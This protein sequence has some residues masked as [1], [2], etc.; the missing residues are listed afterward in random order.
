MSYIV[1]EARYV[2]DSEDEAKK[3]Y[4]ACKANVSSLKLSVKPSSKNYT[5]QSQIRVINCDHDEAKPT[6]STILHKYE[7]SEDKETV[8]DGSVVNAIKAVTP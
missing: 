5:E 6:G 7:I 8:K 2:V 3:L 4:E 1:V